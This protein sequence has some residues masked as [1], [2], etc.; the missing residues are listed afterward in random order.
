M[1][2]EITAIR[3]E[4]ATDD[5]LPD[6]SHIDIQEASGLAIVRLRKGYASPLLCTQLTEMSR[7]MHECA[8]WVQDWDGTPD[9]AHQ[10]VEGRHI[11]S[12]RWELRPPT[13]LPDGLACIPIERPGEIV[14]FIRVGEARPELVDE[15]NRILERIVGDG[16]WRQRWV[17]GDQSA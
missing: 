13:D 3:Y 7:P 11:A 1:Y 12:A 9:R 5:E 14:W 6:G 8:R 10:P 15:M 16:L 2:N 4:N 17:S